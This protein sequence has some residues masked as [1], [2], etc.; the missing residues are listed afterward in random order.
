MPLPRTS[1]AAAPRTAAA[2]AAA[3]TSSALAAAAALLSARAGSRRMTAS[4]VERPDVAAPAAAAA[5]GAAARAASKDA[6]G[7]DARRPRRRVAV[8]ASAG[9]AA[10]AVVPAP[11]AAAGT[12]PQP[13]LAFRPYDAAADLPE[14]QRICAAVCEQTAARSRA[15]A[16]PCPHTLLFRMLSCPRAA[17]CRI[18]IG[19]LTASPSRHANKNNT[20]RQSTAA[21]T[22]R[23]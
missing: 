6:D 10:V 8:A 21:T 19:L 17:V 12:R 7:A 11:E 9:A 4:S 14:I 23:A 13:D 2:S 5:A 20:K 15:G 18:S 1:S 3:A 16:S 22:C